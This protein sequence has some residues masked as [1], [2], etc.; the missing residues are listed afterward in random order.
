MPLILPLLANLALAAEVVWVE[1]VD[2]LDPVMVSA[3]NTQAQTTM[4]GL[5]VGDLRAART[6]W[7]PADD[8]ALKNLE[9]ALKE[10]RKFETKLDGELIIMQDLAA[11]LA[12]VRLVR[13]ETDRNLLFSA[14]AY[15]GFAV[16]RFFDGDLA[17]DEKAAAYRLEMEGSYYELPWT[18]AVAIDPARQV[19]AYEIAEAPQ[20][21]AYGKV[22]EMVAKALPA[23]LTP[24]P[25]GATDVLYIDGRETLPGA[26]GNVK[27]QPGRHLVHVSREGKVI[28]R[29]DLRLKPGEAL[30]LKAS[31]DDAAFKAFVDQL[32]VGQV[33]PPEVAPLISALGGEIWLVKTT[34]GAPQILSVKSDGTAVTKVKIVA[35]VRP[36]D[37]KPWALSVAA[38]VHGGWFS[39]GNFY[40]D[41]FDEAE[42]TKATVNSASVGLSVMGSFDYSVFRASVGVDTVY[43]PG[44][45]HNAVVG[46]RDVA[47]RPM[48]WVGVGVRWLQVHG[49]YL[50]PHH[51]AV[52]ART[53]LTL[54]FGLEFQGTFTYGFG[55]EVARDGAEPWARLPT[56]QAGGG[57]GYRFGGKKM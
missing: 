54:P 32:A 34:T 8:Q 28:E 13:D 31:V 48:P 43:T 14:L 19:S 12:A 26:A 37:E 20:R 35:P 5:T 45:F 16:N 49:G 6:R 50:F 55:G 7:D 33:A 4:A 10:V 39:S 18:D 41:Q 56:F 22:M 17:V 52:G 47:L 2:S 44:D 29:Y 57:L 42:A 27:L 23:S 3:V 15:Q 30:S 53:G 1:P 36:D 25:L 21:V 24:P 38:A 40:T 46:D 51:P 11:P 9:Q